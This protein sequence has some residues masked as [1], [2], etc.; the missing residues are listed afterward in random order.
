MLASNCISRYFSKY[1]LSFKRV[2]AKFIKKQNG[3]IQN[4]TVKPS[5]LT[6][7]IIVAMLVLYFMLAQSSDVAN[8][9]QKGS[10]FQRNRNSKGN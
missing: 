3:D 4:P 8:E 1:T 6:G 5:K 9:E 2:Q 7:D 10:T